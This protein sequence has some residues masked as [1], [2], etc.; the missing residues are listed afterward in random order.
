MIRITGRG[1]A[2]DTQAT[3][4]SAAGQAFACQNAIKG[5]EAYA[6]GLASVRFTD[7][8]TQFVEPPMLTA[9]NSRLRYVGKAYFDKHFRDVRFWQI[10]KL[11]Q[12]DIDGVPVCQI[13]FDKRHVH[14][15]NC[16]PLGIGLNFE[17]IAGPALVLLL[18][19]SHTYCM[20]AGAVDT[21][22]GR[23]GIMAESGAGK[24]TLSGHD[25]SD[26]SQVSDDV[27]PVKFNG[28]DN[29][30]DVLPDFP[31]LKLPNNVVIDAP[32]PAQALDYLLRLNP[33]PSNRIR[34]SVLPKVQAMLQVVRHTV[35][36]KL[37]D[38][39][40]LEQH[41]GFAKKISVLV[42]VIE[43]SYPREIDQLDQLRESVVEYLGSL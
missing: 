11:G 23:I 42:P 5:L 15:L 12:L 24:S 40:T 27:M 14:V 4:Y 28:V 20:H 2:P 8:L 19:Q 36:A 7:L 13:D 10:G 1:Q 32:K 22:V 37:F 34:F 41:A 25:S 16:E 9:S 30:I 29:C 39:V 18:T 35:A 17:L 6:T 26:W 43:V 3:H 33:M 21:P 31:Q 38:T